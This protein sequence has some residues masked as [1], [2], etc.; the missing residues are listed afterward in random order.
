MDSP[1]GGK[2]VLW[3]SKRAPSTTNCAKGP[4]PERN[5]SDQ[6]LS[7]RFC[8]FFVFDSCRLSA[9]YSHKRPHARQ[10]NDPHLEAKGAIS[11]LEFGNI[12]G[13]SRSARGV[14]HN[15]EAEDGFGCC[16][17]A[18]RFS[19][20]H[21]SRSVVSVRQR[22]NVTLRSCSRALTPTARAASTPKRP[23]PSRHGCA[24]IGCS[25]CSRFSEG[26][27]GMRSGSWT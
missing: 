20:L 8:L 24:E 3:I 16:A 23:P 11:N 10:V 19:I 1:G 4:P 25:R 13:R 14:R 9:H 15:C 2:A 5:V 6:T 21:A 17:F 27:R 18:Q 12:G 22:H 26:P 7:S